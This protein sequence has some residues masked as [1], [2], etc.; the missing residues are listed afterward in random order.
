MFASTSDILNRGPEGP[1]RQSGDRRTLSRLRELCEEVLA[2]YRVA[3]GKDVVS[4]D[5]RRA[6]AELLKGVAPLPRKD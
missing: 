1:R 2:S 4:D 6:A 5:D 3:R